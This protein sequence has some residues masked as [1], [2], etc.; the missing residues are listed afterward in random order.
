MVSDEQTGMG[1]EIEKDTM[2]DANKINITRSPKL[3]TTSIPLLSYSDYLKMK[4]I[5]NL[6]SNT[7]QP[8]FF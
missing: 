8:E 4:M 3:L 7:S 1:I 2:A 6:F 5:K